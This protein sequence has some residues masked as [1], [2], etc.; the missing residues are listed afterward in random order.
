[1]PRR[2]PSGI[3]AAAIQAYT[4]ELTKL[5]NR[6]AL[7]EKLSDFEKAGHPWYLP[8]QVMLF[9]VDK[10]KPINDTFGHEVGDRVLAHVARTI[11]AHTREGDFVVR[12]G[13]DEFLVVMPN[14][15]LESATRRAEGIR[16]NVVSSPLTVDGKVLGVTLSI[17]IADR[18]SRGTVP[19]FSDLLRAAD[20]A[21]YPCTCP[22]KTGATGYPA[23]D[24]P[25]AEQS[26][27]R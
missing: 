21:M 26:A 25:R 22:R 20:K 24:P 3:S 8:L 1:M 16:E 12:Y 23:C 6:R 19:N 15:D 14:C 17:G 2:V 27:V 11:E 5:R 18:D 9:D 7:W 13:G 10:F 4:D